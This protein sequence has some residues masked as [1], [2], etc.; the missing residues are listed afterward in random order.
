MK[1]RKFKAEVLPGHKENALEVP[2]DPTKLWGIEPRPLWRGR[3][4]HLV[5]GRLNGC[6]FESFIV[7][8]SKRFY[9]LIDE[10][11]ER[12]AGVTVGDIVE[13]AVAPGTA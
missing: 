6:D 10:E 3:R 8:R 4:G 7:P 9:M 2:F 1:N 11:L 5:Q 12:K 13:V